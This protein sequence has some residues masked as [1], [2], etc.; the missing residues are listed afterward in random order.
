MESTGAYWKPVYYL[1]ERHPVGCRARLAFEAGIGFAIGLLAGAV[2]LILGSLRLPAMVRFL[3]VDPRLAAG[4]NLFI[5][6]LTG[7]AGWLG[8]AAIGAVDYPV[9]VALGASGV[10]GQLHGA[11]L[12]GRAS[13]A[14]LLYTM[15]G[16][17]ALVG[18]LLLREA[19]A[20]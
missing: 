4:T 15:A 7:V 11:R 17:L 12:S 13:I 18:S 9:L 5:G 6:V 10:L 1:L 20:R 14:A 2:G 16:V 19:I 3:G 8:H